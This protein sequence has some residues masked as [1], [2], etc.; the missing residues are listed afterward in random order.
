MLLKE[1]SR[2]E[3][4][5]YNVVRYRMA[6]SGIFR[7]PVSKTSYYAYLNCPNK[8]FSR[9]NKPISVKT[10]RELYY[11][12]KLSVRKVAEILGRSM[13]SI[14]DF[15]KRHNLPRRTPVQT[16]NIAYEQQT[17][18]YN[19]KKK[20]T[21][22]DEKLKMAGIMLYWAEGC[23]SQKVL[24]TNRERYVIDLANSDPRMIQLFV[25]FLREI[26]GVDEN[27]LRVLLYCY[28]NQNVEFLKKYWSQIT[29]IPLKQFIK[30]YV[31]KDFLPQKSGKMKYGL[32][33]IRYS[34][35]KLFLQIRNWI[36]Q[37]LNENVEILPG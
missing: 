28:A 19:L 27:R 31:R 23:K 25:K 9:F 4:R 10:I 26:C 18:S 32:V 36:E 13:S 16:N 12:K 24:G 2:R 8:A 11:Q 15:M 5:P 17:P 22:K 1:M 14:Y 33:H 29:K 20:L 3:R 21:P 34:D 7:K 6:K 35:K 30:P 37:Y